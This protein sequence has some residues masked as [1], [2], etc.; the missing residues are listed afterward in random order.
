MLPA[1][2]LGVAAV[3]AMGYKAWQEMPTTVPEEMVYDRSRQP[4]THLQDVSKRSRHFWTDA[5]DEA[6][7]VVSEDGVASFPPT[8]VLDLFKQAKEKGGDLRAMVSA[9]FQRTWTW[10]QYYDD[11]MQTARALVKLGVSDFGTVCIIGFNSPEWFL[12]NVGA[13]ICGAKAAGIYTTNGPEAAAYIA[14]HSEAEIIVCENAYQVEKF[15]KTLPTL[16]H[17][18]ALV[19]WSGEVP[20]SAQHL[21]I[22]CLKWDEFFHL[23][24]DRDGALSRIVEERMARQRPGHCCTLIYTSGTTG[25]PKA[26]MISHDSLTWTARCVIESFSPLRVGPHEFISYLPLSHVAAQMLDIHA[27]IVITAMGS[28]CCVTFARPDALKGTLADSLRQ[29]RPTGFFGVPRVWEKFHERMMAVGASTTGIRRTIATWAKQIGSQKWL[30]DQLPP[31]GSRVRQSPPVMY[32]VADH[33]V[34]KKVK[35]NLG[36]DRA[37]WFLSGAAPI[38]RD[39]LSYFGSLDMPIL[40]VYG[41]SECCGPSTLAMP[42]AFR[43]GS[44]GP[45]IPGVEL[46]ID[47]DPS[48]DP[49][50]HGEICYR[51]RNVMMGYMKN[52]AKTVEA[53]DKDGWLHSGDVGHLDEYG[54]LSITGRIKELIITAGGENIAPVPI[55]EAIKAAL[56]AISNVMMVGDKRK[57]NVC[58]V[59]L[60]TEL[61]EETGR[62]TDKLVGASLG[63]NGSKAT[64]TQEAKECPVWRS[65]ITNGIQQVNQNAVSNAQ[66]IQKFAIL[67]EDFTDRNGDLTPTLKLRRSVVTDKYQDLIDSLYADGA[68]GD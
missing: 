65:Y 59:T 47:H 55:E 17:V 33:I 28:S 58:L 9:D 11:A 35:Q 36:L 64:T 39:T 16:P 54:M 18:K 51:G 40:E 63:L 42:E 19:V 5:R 52:V 12:A 41:M 46:R 7:V 25:D 62:H 66:K 31:E 49:P 13:I 57:Y 24:E 27:P 21:K 68:G 23:G 44:V 4:P 50:G 3:G 48:R 37:T 10:S 14:N 6:E 56:P 1:A 20:V 60:R 38:T 22:P 2:V 61:N 67:D 30:S 29:I 15:V 32:P 53:I 34:F 8:T 26:V 43:L 45:A